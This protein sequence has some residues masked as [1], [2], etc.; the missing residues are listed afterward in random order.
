MFN[1]ILFDYILYNNQRFELG[2]PDPFPKKIAMMSQV[3]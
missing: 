3:L 1:N 2:L